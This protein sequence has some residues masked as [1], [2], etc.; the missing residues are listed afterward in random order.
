MLLQVQAQVK[1][2]KARFDKL[3]LDTMQKID[4]LAASRCN[5]F[6]HVLVNYQ[7]TLL[8]FWAKTSRTMSAVAE[9]FRGYQYYEF[10]MLKV[11]L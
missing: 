11:D 2:T 8:H 3:K 5:M 7:T 6:S 9:S 10:N 1:K 4:L